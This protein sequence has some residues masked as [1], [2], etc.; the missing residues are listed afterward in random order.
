MAGHS[1]WAG[2]KH[3][4]AII[5]AKRGKLWTKLLKEVTVA[6]RLG[7]GD[8]DG[9]PRLRSAIQDARGANCPKDTIDRAV[10]KGTGELE[11]LEYVEVSYE[12]YGPGGVA[13]LVDTMTDNRNRTVAELRHLFSKNGGNLGESG[14]VAWMFDRRAQF[15]IPKDAMDEESFVE[16]AMELEAEDLATDGD[17][18]E[19]YGAVEDYNR[20]RESLEERELA[21]EV[22]QLAQIPQ[23]TIRVDE[24]DTAGQLLGLLE[25]LEDHDDVQSVW[26]NFDIDDELFEQ[27]AS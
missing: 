1:K 8:P 27:A 6:A 2:I 17:A 11:G 4:K 21:L 26:A 7:G 14:C 25:A 9:N 15:A 19:L 23:N 10:K 12:G 3:K 22:K 24:E 5:D 13:I 18:Y 20:L 16:L